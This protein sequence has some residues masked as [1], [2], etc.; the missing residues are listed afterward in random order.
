[1][2]NKLLLCSLPP[3]QNVLNYILTAERMLLQ[4]NIVYDYITPYSLSCEKL[5][6]DEK[7]LREL[8]DLI[9]SGL[10]LLKEKSEAWEKLSTSILK[11]NL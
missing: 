10:R 1:L 8:K 6:L 7:G 2:K 5:I 9:K 3:E 4:L 11:I